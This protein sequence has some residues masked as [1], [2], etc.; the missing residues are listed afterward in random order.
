MP[1]CAASVTVGAVDTPVAAR[2]RVAGGDGGPDPHG[3]LPHQQPGG[4]Q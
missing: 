1:Y 4:H 3:G 2:A